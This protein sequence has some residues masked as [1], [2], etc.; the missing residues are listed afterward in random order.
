L[1]I[2][3]GVA[4]KNDILKTG[5][6]ILDE[7][8]EELSKDKKIDQDLHSVLLDLWKQRRLY[9]KTYLMHELDDL[10]KEKSK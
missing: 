7:Y 8:F 1:A 4:L 10:L 3:W 5:V 6:E 2:F 9:T